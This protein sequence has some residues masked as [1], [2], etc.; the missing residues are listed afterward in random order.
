M[1]SVK[2]ETSDDIRQIRVDRHGRSIT[3]EENVEQRGAD[4]DEEGEEQRGAE[5][6]A[7]ARPY[8]EDLHL[9]SLRHTKWGTN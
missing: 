3:A 5:E 4:D 8:S 1:A 6:G 2:E 9:N 7:G